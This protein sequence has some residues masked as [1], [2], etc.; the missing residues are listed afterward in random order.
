VARN[1]ENGAEFQVRTVEEVVWREVSDDT[2]VANEL[3]TESDNP[4]LF[5]AVTVSE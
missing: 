4:M 5:L 3:V 2:E 1:Q